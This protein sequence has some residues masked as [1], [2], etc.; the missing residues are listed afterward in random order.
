MKCITSSPCSF[1]ANVQ[2]QFG[3]G[4]GNGGSLC[5]FKS[6]GSF[7]FLVYVQRLCVLGLQVF[8]RR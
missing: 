1:H 7:F 8:D 3:R 5:G 2:C 6:N 4:R